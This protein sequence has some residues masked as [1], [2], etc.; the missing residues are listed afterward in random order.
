MHIL[1]ELQPLDPVTG[2]RV[3]LRASSAQLRE[4]TGLNGARW[5][6]AITRK[7]SIG[8]QTFE[9]DF[10]S[11]IEP[12]GASLQIALDRLERL[13]G[14]SRRFIWAG[15]PIKIYSGDI[16]DA[17]PWTTE[18]VG[19]TDKFQAEANRLSVS[20]KVDDEPFQ[21]EV[22]YLSYAGTTGL[23]GGAD[24]KGK[25]K[26]WAFGACKNV[27][28][29]LI[30]AINSVFQVSAYGAIK[31]VPYLYERGASLGGSVGDYAT[32]A[33]LV[34]ASIPEG[35]WGTCLAQGLVRTGA[36]PYGIITI[37]VEGDFSGSVWRRKPGAILQRIAAT[38]SVAGSAI[39][40]TSLNAWDTALASLPAGGNI[41]LFLSSQEKLLD[42]A[43]RLA[44]G[45]NYQAGVSL[46]GQ[47]FAVKPVI[48]SPTM[49]LDARGRQKPRVSGVLESDV[50]PPYSKIQMGG[51]RS[52]RVHSFDEIAFQATL[53]EKGNYS[54]SETYREGN[55]VYQTADGARYVY[56]NPVATSGNAPPNATYWE[57]IQDSA[58]GSIP[59]G[60]NLVV[61]SE[62]T[63]GLTGWTGGWDGTV[64]L[65]VSRGLDLAG[66]SGVKHVAYATA[67]GT[68]AAGSV[69]D[70]FVSLGVGAGN[71][72]QR[73]RWA[74]S[75]VPNERLYYS[76]RVAGHRCKP[77]ANLQFSDAAGNYIA[78]EYQSEQA[79]MNVPNFSNGD[80]ENATRVG[81]FADV[82][83]GARF[84]YLNVRAVC[85][86]GQANPYIFFTDGFIAKV[87][88]GQTVP[89]PYTQGPGDRTADRTGEN[90]ANN[91]AN[92]GGS[93]AGTVEG[94]A[95]KANN[96]LDASG[97][98]LNGKV[99]TPA[100]LPNTVIGP[101]QV[102]LG[103]PYDISTKNAWVDVLS[104]TLSMSG[105]SS[106]VGAYFDAVAVYPSA[107][108]GAFGYFYCRVLRGG[109]VLKQWLLA[110][111]FI[112]NPADPNAVTFFEIE[113][114]MS[115]LDTP[116]GGNNTYK[117]Q[118]YLVS[119][120][121]EWPSGSY[122]RVLPPTNNFVLDLK[123]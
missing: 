102:A 63:N 4:I 18:F 70:A 110:G 64:G 77:F 62:F 83:T 67:T 26:P 92:V 58:V 61:N 71:L 66:W 15:A 21:K 12:G 38:L 50:S 68:P 107:T 35:R 13:D 34:A 59:L 79:P 117:V 57:K 73:R 115:G 48:G 96:G 5:W 49:T 46:V 93:S 32:Y 116:A 84:A 75:V 45:C 53:V 19:R 24:L 98:V 74:L 30:D 103:S 94:G 28:P 40:T 17:W 114:M 111:T 69:F 52:W 95:N 22:L 87:N 89:P 65:P 106:Q 100:L 31:A 76:A 86:G 27:E 55:I 39:D 54:A 88:P 20:A 43:Q 9:G 123:R 109:A 56:I 99:N 36:P 97:N 7:P 44:L 105:S 29:V 90:T 85:P 2:L 119:G 33:A 41:N 51:N 78:P 14:N 23:E 6:P 10:S 60:S 101:G 3:T 113:K 72:D 11:S 120:S 81:D 47:L 108:G 1:A 8:L 122:L 91:T 42:L 16:G 121:G 25:P 112:N 37:D 118:V 80:P 82:P 104:Q